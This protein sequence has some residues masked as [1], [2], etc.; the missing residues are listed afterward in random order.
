MPPHDFGAIAVIDGR[1][2]KTTPF[3]TASVPPPMSMF[4]M[5]ASHTVIDVAFAEDNSRM[6]VLHH[7]GVDIYNWQTRNGRSLIPRLATA[8]RFDDGTVHN[9]LQ[10][11]FA[12]NGKP[13]ILYFKNGLQA[14]AIVAADGDGKP[15]VEG[16]VS[17]D[18]EVSFMQASSVPSTS[19]Q[20]RGIIVQNR[21]GRLHR[22]TS[23]ELM[24][25]GF[26][27]QLP[28]VDVVEIED[29]LVAFGMSRNGHLY[30]N[31]RLL[32]K[33]CTSFLVTCDHLIFTTSNHL[34]KFVHLSRPGGNAI[35]PPPPPGIYM[36]C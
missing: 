22:L 36:A 23:H 34:L 11:A 10:V 32:V 5:E 24:P 1:M 4:D 18:E 15:A 21:S 25:T 20:G 9:A 14:C 26:P 3:R 33:N 35:R 27:V 31:S 8:Y 7:G 30:A 16:P 13:F 2:V 6:A 29:E 28:W 12:P 19:E 17:L